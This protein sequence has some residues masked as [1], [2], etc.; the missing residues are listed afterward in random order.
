MTS[1]ADLPTGT[2]TFLFTDIQGSTRLLE[3]LGVQY[4]DVLA[5]HRRIVR[6]AISAGQGREIG[7]EGDSFFVVF[8]SALGAVESIVLLQ[9]GLAAHPWPEGAQIRVRSGLH[10]GEGT[11]SDGGYVGLD[12]HRAARIA[13]AG[14]GGQV[15]LSGATRSVVEHALPDG[16]RIR[17]LGMHRLRDLDDP[18]HLFQLDIAGLPNDHPALRTL[19]ARPNNLPAQVT[20]FI[21][22]AADIPQVMELLGRE[23]LVTLTGPGG[24]GK[25]RLAMHVGAEL[26]DRY[27][28]GVFFV[29][30]API[31]QAGLVPSAIASTLGVRDS[32]DLALLEALREHLRR[33]HMLL[34][35]DNFEQ[36]TEA[37]TLVAD[38]LSWAPDLRVLAT[39]RVALNVQGEHE[40]PVPP[41]GLPDASEATSAEILSGS[42]AVALFIE[43]SRAVRPD[44]S[45]TDESLR[46]IAAIVRRLDGLPLAI[47]LA[48]ARTKIFAP[49]ALLPRLD[50]AL[51]LLTTGASDL[52]AR[53]RTLRDA[54]AWSYGLLDPGERR[55]FDGLS[56][57]AG[58]VTLPAAE[59]VAGE[60]SG[61]SAVGDALR[62]LTRLVD[63]S[64]L[65]VAPDADGEPRFSFLETIREFATER[66]SDD[67]RASAR[68]RH[69]DYFIAFAESADLHGR[70]PEQ[71]AWLRRL[72]DDRENIRAALTWALA[73][74]DGG[75]ALRLSAA[76]DKQF[77]Y[78]AGGA[79]EGL[80]ILEA[81]L[82]IGADAPLALRAK[83]LQRAGWILAD[84][85]E[86]QRAAD[87]FEESLA[88]YRATG[89]EAGMAEALMGLA[90]KTMETSDPGSED[91]ILR[92]A[93]THAERSG[94]AAPVG[95]IH[96]ALG[97]AALRRGDEGSARKNFEDAAAIATEAQDAWGKAWALENLMGIA[98]DNADLRQAEAL[99]SEAVDLARRSGD[100]MLVESALIVLASARIEAG[101]LDGARP[102][103]EAGA[104]TANQLAT[105]MDRIWMVELVARW[106][107]AAGE[108]GGALAA[109]AAATAARAEPGQEAR[110]L[111]HT[112]RGPGHPEWQRAHE[113]LARLY[114]E[115]F[116]AS[117]LDQTLRDAVPFA[118]LEDALTEALRSM[119]QSALRAVES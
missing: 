85:G 69:A 52:P 34:V 95:E 36:V 31:S 93:L 81:A 96:V 33:R 106:L 102:L 83:G 25:T 86:L 19:D 92:E 67:D 90:Y 1:A 44:F 108:R 68:L 82:A 45:A 62:N 105:A 39:S 70:G 3:R 7:T 43:R 28:D 118:Q 40:H 58:G 73:E 114:V 72:T 4:A 55:F 100:S 23:R 84:G 51:S 30:L 26:L 50:H 2:V 88:G 9:R 53:Q 110:I 10:T 32:T 111:N 41:L 37:A 49:A 14:D 116:D 113:G 107:L 97:I 18:E 59:V 46:T 27:P 94:L 99:A 11:L 8:P 5:Q 119:R 15:L 87:R 117:G 64:L 75:R 6:D 17:D 38:M 22:R 76:F 12:V 21:G 13:A 78:A 35:L 16:V 63:N 98:V 57:F 101:D 115:A 109:W 48:A 71:T 60:A 80:R 29:D 89:N 54:I 61:P 47:E 20:S 104:R 65:Q 91:E 103:I 112:A 66:L 79:A 74:G 24:S 77:W 42:D 56:V